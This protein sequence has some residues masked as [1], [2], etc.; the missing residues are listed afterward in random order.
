[1]RAGASAWAFVLLAA[2][3]CTEPKGP[4]A[5][6]LRV[7]LPDGWV[8]RANAS[9]TLEVG[10]KGRVVLT[11]DRKTGALPAAEVLRAAVESEGGGVVD[12]A[13][14]TDAVQVRYTK[15]GRTGLLMVRPLEGQ[16][17]LLCATT[18]EAT[19]DELAPSVALCGQ[20]GLEVR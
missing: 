2:A 14:A 9:G 15:G 20:V 6:A 17:L 3:A 10:P 7:P 4:R 1:M 12:A 16:A 13:T 8:A 19:A 18:P 5:T 11:L